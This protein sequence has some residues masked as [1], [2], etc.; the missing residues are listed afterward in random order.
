MTPDERRRRVEYVVKMAKLGIMLEPDYDDAD[1]C[2]EPASADVWLGTMLASESVLR[3]DW[4]RPEEDADWS[5][6]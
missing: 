1:G 2:W 3:R 6:L 5:D 4:D